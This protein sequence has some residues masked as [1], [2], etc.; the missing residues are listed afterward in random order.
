MQQVAHDGTCRLL[1]GCAIGLL[2]GCSLSL[3]WAAK[4]SFKL[5]FSC[6][7][8]ENFV[9]RIGLVL[10]DFWYNER[11]SLNQTSA[12]W[13]NQQILAHLVFYSTSKLSLVRDWR[14]GQKQTEVKPLRGGRKRG[15]LHESDLHGIEP[16]TRLAEAEICLS[17][18]QFAKQTVKVNYAIMLGAS[19]FV[20][21]HV[22]LSLS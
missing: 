20:Q 21:I 22:A 5:L 4:L 1:V 17:N 19:F 10:R 8:M 3:I 11:A 18:F 14:S 13:L 2:A 12:W 7:R 9:C 15:S 6:F 16:E